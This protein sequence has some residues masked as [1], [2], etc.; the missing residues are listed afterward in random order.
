MN[1]SFASRAIT[2][3]AAW[4]GT[5]RGYFLDGDLEQRI[6]QPARFGVRKTSLQLVSLVPRDSSSRTLVP[7]SID[8]RLPKPPCVSALGAAARHHTPD[9]QQA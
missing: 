7:V 1:S 4:S 2:G 9:F 8:G 6:A 5:F 3:L